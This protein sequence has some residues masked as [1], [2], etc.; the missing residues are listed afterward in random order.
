MQFVSYSFFIIFPFVVLANY[1]LPGKMRPVW[2]LSAGL[3]L[4]VWTEPIHAVRNLAVLLSIGTVTYRAGVLLSEIPDDPDKAPGVRMSA[5]ECRAEKKRILICALLYIIGSLAFWKYSRMAFPAAR[6]LT[7][8]LGISFYALAAAGYVIDC[9][10]DSSRVEKDPLYCF[11][12]V[13]FFPLTLSGPIE[14]GK[15]LIPQFRDPVPFSLDR[16][17]EGLS[18][19][20]W[21]FFLKLVLADRMALLVDPVY[22]DP[23]AFGGALI[24]LAVIFYSLEI[25]CDF[26]GYSCIARGA[27]LILGIRVMENFESPYFSDSIAVFWRRWHISLSSW[28]RDYL[29]IPLGGGRRSAAVK[30]RNIL[31]VFA[32]SGLWHGTG[33]TFLIWGLLH[34]VYEV[35]GASLTPLRRKLKDLTGIRDERLS[36]RLLK[37]VF[38]FF[39]TSLAWVFFR[40]PGLQDASRIF[41]GLLHPDL[42]H[43]A[44]G[45][46]PRLGLDI[47]NMI[48]LSSGLV[49]LFFADILKSRGYCLRRRIMDQG[50]WFR[51]LIYIGGV[52]LIA[53][54]GIWGA[55]YNAS[56]FIYSQF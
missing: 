17:R 6:S 10:R 12:F 23:G 14:R 7:A 55:G 25:Y 46:L 56:S 52:V 35:V 38:T 21:G 32:V 4:H 43:L 3:L 40:A 9:Y 18:M 54:C 15:N 1:L 47:P 31:I 41:E 27:S 37:I 53:V 51:W 34:G 36:H 42:Y 50:P 48:L 19:M 29:Y 33:L 5:A 16:T 11:L 44:D 24:L 22:A 39:L 13:S 28:F 30:Y 49:L 45:T 8:P 2:L 20:L 26:Y